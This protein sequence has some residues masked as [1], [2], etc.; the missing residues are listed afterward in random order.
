MVTNRAGMRWIALALASIGSA[1]GYGQIPDLLNALDAGGR[2]MGVGGAFGVTDSATTSV[3]QNPASLGFINSTQVGLNFRNLP[4]SSRVVGGNFNNPV[5]IGESQFGKRAV[6]HFG[7]ATPMAG[8]AFGISYT[9]GGFIDD[10]RNGTNLDNGLLRVDNYNE[11]L[12]AQTDFFAFSYGRNQGSLNWGFGL[13][14]ANQ[15]VANDRSFILIDPQSN[16][17][18]G[19][20]QTNLSGNGTGIGAVAGVQIV[21]ESNPNISYALSVRTPINLTGNASTSSY[22]D[23]VPGRVGFGFVARNDAAGRDE[24]FLVYGIQADYYFGGQENKVLSRKNHLVLGAG[25]EYNMHRWNARWPLRIGYAAVP[26]GGAG[27]SERNSLTFGLGYRPNGGRFGI[28][29][30]FASP[31]GGPLDMSLGLNYTLKGN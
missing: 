7:F 17:Q 14:V 4:T 19:S 31:G 10:T 30:N 1:I 28:D 25:F 6:S 23:R 27:F 20:S 16:Q 5:S 8:G 22:I 11:R 18:V 26:S 15:Y 12:R 29:L 3:L 24:D 2:A 21:P 13:V 9:I